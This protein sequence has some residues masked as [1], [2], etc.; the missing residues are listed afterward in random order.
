MTNAVAL[1]V[2]REER[3][4]LREHLRQILEAHGQKAQDIIAYSVSLGITKQEASVLGL[5]VRRGVVSLE[6]FQ[7]MIPGSDIESNILS[8]L[9]CRI[10]ST[11]R[12]VHGMEDVI[13]TSWGAGY[14]MTTEG[15]QR[16][17]EI[18]ES[19]HASVGP[20]CASVQN[21]IHQARRAVAHHE[22]NHG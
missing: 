16:I 4:T 19:F 3:D 10:R 9:I 5:L 22:Q 13:K 15:R 21:S 12:Q 8:T 2:L 7:V 18:V 14:Y 6:Q 17:K 20:P 1:S 11:L